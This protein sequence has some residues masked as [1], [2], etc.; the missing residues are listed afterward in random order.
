M[1]DPPDAPRASDERGMLFRSFADGVAAVRE[2]ARAELARRD[3]APVRRRRDRALA[4]AAPRPGAALRSH[5]GGALAR[6]AARLRRGP[7]RAALR[8][9]E[10]RRRQGRADD[11]PRAQRLRPQRRPAA[12]S[13]ARPRR[14][15]ANASE[16]RICATGCSIT[17]SPWTRWRRRCPGRGS[18]RARRGRA[19]AA[20]RRCDAR[21]GGPRDGAPLAQ[22]PR[23]RV[24]LLHA[25]STRSKPD[26]RSSSGARSSATPPRRSSRRA[27]RSR[28]TTASASITSRGWR[29]RRASL[30]VEALRAREAR[31][32]SRRRDEPGEAA[33]TAAWTLSERRAALSRAE[34]DG[35]DVLVVGGGIVGAG[36]L[37]DAASRGLRALLIERNDF[38][39]GTSSRSS[40]MVHGGLRYLAH[41][42]LAITREACRERDLLLRMNPNLVKP[43]PFLFCA[44]RTASTPAW[45]VRAALSVVLRARELPPLGALPDAVGRRGDAVLARLPPGRLARAPGS[46][47]TRRWTTRASSSRPSRARGGSAPKRPTT[48]RLVEFLRGSDGQLGG[49]RVRDALDGRTLRIHAGARGERRR[50]GDRARARPRP[51]GVAARTPPREG[52]AHRDPARAHPRARA[53]SR[54]SRPRT[55][56]AC[57]CARSTT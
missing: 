5:R 7:L 8:R 9:R 43:L 47:T 27:A 26:A 41:G 36:V 53:R 29:A 46:T 57:S 21:G 55:G 24:P 16:L 48:P 35:V 49:A 42:H 40:K 14:G 37:R 45:Q 11:A 6:R 25:C 15:G 3:D 33:V 31:R 1:R 38:A 28:I 34:R 39:S 56:V 22:L 18:R 17:A 52:R 20:R 10:Q 30:G 23:R 13:L 51:A 54:S 2:A 44:S 50:S 4:A 19:R 12:R 32:R